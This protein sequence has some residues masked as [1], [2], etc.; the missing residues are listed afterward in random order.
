MGRI[1][2]LMGKSSTGKD[3][4]FKRLLADGELNLSTIVTYTTR[5]IREG[6]EEG[7]EYHFIDDAKVDELERAGKIVELRAYNTV[8]GI[9]KYMTVDDGQINLSE[10]SYL[11]IGTPE[12]YINVAAHFGKNAIVPIMLVLDDGERLSRALARERVQANPKYE[13]LCRRFLADAKD[14]SE[15][16]LAPIEGGR[17]FENIELDTCVSEVKGYI[18]SL[19]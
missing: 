13:E 7:R 9:W 12:A 16:N 3:T 5:P 18:K 14:F 10:R 11:V 6:E 17:T 2:Y 8:H 1:F 15:E 4:V 19:L